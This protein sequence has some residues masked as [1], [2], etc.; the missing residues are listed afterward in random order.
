MRCEHT[1]PKWAGASH[2]T[3]PCGG[4]LQREGATLVLGGQRWHVYRCPLFNHET[5]ILVKPN[6]GEEQ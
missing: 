4:E 3:K 5:R 2:T 1:I 6:D